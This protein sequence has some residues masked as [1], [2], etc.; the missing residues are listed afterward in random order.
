MA[1][2]KSIRTRGKIQLS[3]F[4]QKFVKG[5]KVAVTREISVKSNFPERL[6]GRTGVIEEKKGKV[7]LVKIKDQEKEKSF[8]IEPIHLKKLK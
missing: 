6:Q 5:D 3:K 1:R 8:L 7:Y 4:F 2:K